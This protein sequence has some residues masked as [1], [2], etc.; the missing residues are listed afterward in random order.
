MLTPEQLV[1]LI[2]K[3]SKSIDHVKIIASYDGG[4]NWQCKVIERD[5]TANQWTPKGNPLD[6]TVVRASKLERRFPAKRGGD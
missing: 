1:E 5:V 6:R 2:E 3:I 4:G